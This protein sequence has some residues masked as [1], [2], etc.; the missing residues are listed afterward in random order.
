MPLL[1]ICYL[2][3]KKGNTV[4]YFGKDV[5]MEAIQSYREIKPFTHLAFHL[6]TNLTDKNADEYVRQLADLFPDTK[7]I[8]SGTQVLAVTQKPGNVR[9]LS[10]MKEILSFVDEFTIETSAK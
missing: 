4:V 9:L 10:S 5:S 3:K 8:M 2:L 7:V 6:V 1:F